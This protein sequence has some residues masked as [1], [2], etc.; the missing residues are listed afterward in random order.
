[1]ADLK[2]LAEELVNL[3]VKE[4]N[5][6]SDILKDEYGIM[7]AVRTGQLTTVPLEEVAEGHNKLDEELYKANLNLIG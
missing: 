2:K 7:I 6:L 4:V 1:M 5:D 3:T